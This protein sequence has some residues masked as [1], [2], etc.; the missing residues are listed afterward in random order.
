MI[1][2]AKSEEP[3]RVMVYG[4]A[5]SEETTHVRRLLT[6]W[7][8]PHHYIDID[9]DCYAKYKVARWNL[10]S[11]VMPAVTIGAL[12]NPRLLAPSEEE[13]HAMLYSA[14]LVRIGPLLL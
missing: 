8:I 7:G 1:R 12:E 6:Q 5:W 2:Y 11:L 13:L 10:G 4:A 14:D 9:K 3:E